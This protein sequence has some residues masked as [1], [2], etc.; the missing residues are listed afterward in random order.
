[1]NLALAV[2]Q[3]CCAFV[4]YDLTTAH[5]LVQTLREPVSF[6]Y[7]VGLKTPLRYTSNIIPI[8]I[9][10]GKSRA[11]VY[12]P[13]YGVVDR[14]YRNM[15][16]TRTKSFDTLMLINSVI[17]KLNM[18]K[19]PV[20]QILTEFLTKPEITPM[21]FVNMAVKYINLTVVKPGDYKRKMNRGNAYIEEMIMKYG[22]KTL[23]VNNAVQRLYRQTIPRTDNAVIGAII[24]TIIEKQ[25]PDLDEY[26]RGNKNYEFIR[27]SIVEQQRPMNVT[28]IMDFPEP[29]Y[30]AMDAYLS[31]DELAYIVPQITK[32]DGDWVSIVNTCINASIEDQKLD[33]FGVLDGPMFDYLNDI[34]NNNTLLWISQATQADGDE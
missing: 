29:E 12:E 23:A 18:V 15:Y 34:A 9:D 13:K 4:H 30:L 16:Q 27:K 6:D 24:R 7:H 20:P 17:E 21:K 25:I 14:G 11:V 5:V 8:I 1:M 32:I 3:I 26:A 19:K 33:I 28:M 10:Y 2:A 31:P 22:D